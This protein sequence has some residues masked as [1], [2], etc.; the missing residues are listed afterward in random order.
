MNQ[1]ILAR[2]VVIS[3]GLFAILLLALHL[4]QPELDPTWSFI[5]E[6]ARGRFGWLMSLAFAALAVTCISGAILFWKSIP[7]WAGRTG[8]VL[9]GLSSIGMIL[10]AMFVT[11]PI[12]TP[13]DQLTT[14]GTLHSVGGQL[15]LT[16]FAILFLTIGLTK[17]SRWKT[18]KK[19]LWITTVICILADIAFI[20][21]AAS[22]N[23]VFGPGVY[24]GMFG[25]IMMLSFVAWVIIAG[26]YLY[27]NRA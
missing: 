26:T 19:P 23:G 20:G 9:L 22:S 15:N 3:G 14:S 13:M 7:G 10:A 5:S 24:T 16:S 11:D 12:N 6:Y 4:V 2:S 17:N 27:K 1:T 25:R 8:S 21:T 18:V